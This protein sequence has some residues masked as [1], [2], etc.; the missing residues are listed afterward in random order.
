MNDAYREGYDAFYQA[1]SLDANPY[2]SETEK[3]RWDDGWEDAKME[4]DLKTR[5]ICSE[6]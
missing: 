6:P 1:A 4:A 5:S 3:K 2:Q